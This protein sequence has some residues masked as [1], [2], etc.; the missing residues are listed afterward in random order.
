MTALGLFRSCSRGVERDAHGY[1]VRVTDLA[2]NGEWRMVDCPW[3]TLKHNF[4]RFLRLDRHPSIIR[5]TVAGWHW[6]YSLNYVL[7]LV[8]RTFEFL[9]LSASDTRTIRVNT[10]DYGKSVCWACIADR[11][12]NE[13]TLEEERERERDRLIVLIIIVSRKCHEVCI[14]S[15][16]GFLCRACSQSRRYCRARLSF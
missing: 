4:F 11:S 8:T 5:W 6:R 9:S 7:I 15:K 3:Q 14:V 2:T 13:Q 1:V 10:N 16:V 12:K